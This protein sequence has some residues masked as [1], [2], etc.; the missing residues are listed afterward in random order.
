M[1]EDPYKVLGVSKTATQAEIKKAYRTLAKKLHPDL[2]PD[3][4]GKQVEFQEVSA[5]YDLLG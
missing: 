2:H 5:A 1:S 3:D 4:A